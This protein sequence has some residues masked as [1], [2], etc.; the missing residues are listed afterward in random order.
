MK[1]LLIRQ[2]KDVFAPTAKVTSLVH[3]YGQLIEYRILN[4]EGIGTVL[5]ANDIKHVLL[6]RLSAMK[7]SGRLLTSANEIYIG[8]AADKSC[9][10]NKIMHIY[11]TYPEPNS[12][13]NDTIIGLYKGDDNLENLRRYLSEPLNKISAISVHSKKPGYLLPGF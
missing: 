5:L 13:F 11:L 3:S 7:A 8:V 2:R 9:W 6:K 12:P 1:A 4:V 10:I